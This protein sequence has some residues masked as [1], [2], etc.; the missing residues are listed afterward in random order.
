M[1]I[2]SSV[3]HCPKSEGVV[4]YYENG[5][6]PGYKRYKYVPIDHIRRIEAKKREKK[7]RTTFHARH[8]DS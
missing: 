8:F 5:I 1:Y 2:I 3:G 6:V 4:S 7:I